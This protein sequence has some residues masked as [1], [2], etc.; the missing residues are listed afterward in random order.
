MLNGT[1]I[2][3]Y[4]VTAARNIFD[5]KY[6][7]VSTDSKK[8]KKIVENEGLQVPFIR[9]KEISADSS[10]AREVIIHAV[11]FFKTKNNYY[12]DK[13]IYLQPTSPL[14]NS[15]HIKEAILLFNDSLD[16]VVS[17]NK[18]K[19][20]PY[21][22]LYEEDSNGFLNKSKKN[23][24]FNRQECKDVYSFNGAIY[25]INVKSIIDS[26]IGDFKKVL[27]YEM[28]TYNSIDI[29]EQLDFDF[30]EFLIKRKK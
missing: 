8:I 2:I 24:V 6:I 26:E 20:N 27:K 15:Q 5:D 29:D 25:I 1:P 21:F 13:L 22:N 11:E 16:M 3:I 19:Y 23:N 17:V 4:T 18:S 9:P 12:P 10:S 28:N 7:Y 30:A 14:R